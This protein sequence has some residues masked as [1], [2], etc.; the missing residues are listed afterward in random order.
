M[1]SKI[2]KLGGWGG[3]ARRGR[4]KDYIAANAK[5]TKNFIF[6]QIYFPGK[7]TVHFYER[8]LHDRSLL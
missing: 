7:K 6:R 5:T 2:N 3:T 8:L 4:I 1:G